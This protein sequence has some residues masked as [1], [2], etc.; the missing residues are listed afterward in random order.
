MC[1]QPW[2]P[3][4]SPTAR[5]KRPV[6]AGMGRATAG[7]AAPQGSATPALPAPGSRR[8]QSDATAPGLAN[9]SGCLHKR[10]GVGRQAAPVGVADMW[11]TGMPPSGCQEWGMGGGRLKELWD[12]QKI[13]VL[14]GPAGTRLIPGPNPPH[15]TEQNS[16]PKHPPPTPAPRCDGET[17]AR[18]WRGWKCGCIRA[19]GGKKQAGKKKIKQTKNPKQTTTT[20]KQQAEE[21]EPESPEGKERLREGKAAGRSGQE[22]CREHP[23]PPAHHAAA[24]NRC[25]V[26]HCHLEKK[27]NFPSSRE[28]WIP[29][30]PPAR[31]H[32]P[33]PGIATEPTRDGRACRRKGKK[34]KNKTSQPNTPPE[35]TAALTAQIAL[36]I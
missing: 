8:C 5:P 7:A 11:D 14:G 26:G 25:W 22:A 36:V 10:G 28:G 15:P 13:P 33:L 23:T 32:R 19:Q 12:V 6:T 18:R 1:P 35:E 20:K 27:R 30:A 2:E 9:A 3:P 4:V 24:K 34:N 21:A 31:L 29:R 16:L 17:E